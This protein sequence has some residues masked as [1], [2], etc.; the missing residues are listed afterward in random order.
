MHSSS[1]AL[2][3]VYARDAKA[4]P[5][6]P[7]QLKMASDNEVPDKDSPYLSYLDIVLLLVFVLVVLLII[8]KFRRRAKGENG[9]FTKRLS[10]NPVYVNPHIV[11]ILEAFS[12]LLLY[13]SFL[14]FSIKQI[15]SP[16]FSSSLS[17]SGNFLDKMK[18]RKKRVIVFYGS[19]T[20]T[21]EEFANRLAKDSSRLGLAAMTFDPEDCT[22]W[23]SIN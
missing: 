4:T 20:G 2:L 3:H 18:T 7:P 1:L 21:G 12:F 17:V 11:V 9:R 23:V 16:N 5:S 15:S 10:I 8:R 19:Q 6:T 14:H 22:D 13:F